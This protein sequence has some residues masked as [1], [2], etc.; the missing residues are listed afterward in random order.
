MPGNE[1]ICYAKNFLGEAVAQVQFSE[2]P[3]VLGD[4]VLPEVIQRAIKRRY[5]IFEPSVEI[6]QHLEVSS[7]QVSA[8][9]SE[10]HGWMFHGENREKTIKLTGKQLHVSNRNYVSFAEFKNDF[11]E[12][13]EEIIKLDPSIAVTRTGVRFVNQFDLGCPVGDLGRYFSPMISSNI[14]FLV[15]AER[16]S[17]Q[18]LLTH[19]TDD[20]WKLR[21]QSGIFNPDFPAVIKKSVFVLDLDC[22]L[23]TPHSISEVPKLVDSLHGEIQD[24]FESLITDNLRELMNA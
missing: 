5:K 18:V 2:I 15:D 4:A 21:I 16:C 1:S 17:R 24:K 7:E 13:L 10:L 23:D 11:T 6:E 14:Q 8:K 20:N 19:Y 3:S 22:Y 9:R 12:P